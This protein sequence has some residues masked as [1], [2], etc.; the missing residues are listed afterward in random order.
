MTNKYRPHVLVLPED[1]ANRQIANGFV[2]NDDLIPRAIQILPIAGGWRKVVDA[3]KNE[4]FTSLRRY[5]E[6]RLVLLIDFDNDLSRPVSIKDQIPGDISDRVF[7]LG[8]LSEPEEL[9]AQMGYQGLESIGESL[10]RDC[11][12]NTQIVWGHELL[13]HNQE[14]LIRL[15]RLVKPFLFA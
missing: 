1:D 7:I 3:L 12:D 13:N 10:S 8:V 6:R 15:I 14:E 9:K 11:S 2:T 5:P 4:Y